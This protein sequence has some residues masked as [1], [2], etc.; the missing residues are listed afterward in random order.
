MH[1]AL[2]LVASNTPANHEESNSSNNKP[3]IASRGWLAQQFYEMLGIF[4]TKKNN[5]GTKPDQQASDF[6]HENQKALLQTQL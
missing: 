3:F 2:E 6:Y 1:K 4:L 5:N